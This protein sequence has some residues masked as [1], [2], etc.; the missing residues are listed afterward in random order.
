MC[1][2]PCFG[3][4]MNATVTA[5]SYDGSSRRRQE[6]DAVLVSRR[7]FAAIAVVAVGGLLAACRPMPPGVPGGD[8]SGSGGRWD[9]H[10]DRTQRR[11]VPDVPEDECVEPERGRAA[12]PL[13]LGD[14]GAEHQLAG[15]DE[16]APRFRRGGRLRHP[17]RGRARHSAQGADRLHRLRRRERSGPVPHSGEHARS[18]AVRRATATGT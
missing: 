10:G 14:A 16:S 8:G 5:Q 17:V 18:R 11:G 13:R 12:R 15:Q 3:L 6:A 2:M 1:T 4:G 9:D 7:I